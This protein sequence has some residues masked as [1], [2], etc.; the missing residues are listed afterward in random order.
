MGSIA[1]VCLQFGHSQHRLLRLEL[2]FSWSEYDDGSGNACGYAAVDDQ[3]WYMALSECSRANAAFSLYGILKGEEDAGCTSKTYINSFFTTSGAET[4]TQYMEFAGASFSGGNDDQA[5]ELSSACT[6]EAG[7]N[8]AA[9]DGYQYRHNENIARGSTSYSLACTTEGQYVEKAFSGQYCKDTENS[10]VTDAL[11]TF[12][13]EMGQIQCT[14]IY[15][16]GGNNNDDGGGESALDLLTVSEPC[17]ILEYP[18]S[19]PDPYRKLVRYEN[20][21]EVSAALSENQRKDRLR[22]AA[23][24]LM[25]LIG[26]LLILLSIMSKCS[27]ENQSATNSGQQVK[28]PSLW[29]KIK[30]TFGRIFLRRRNRNN[31][32]K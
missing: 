2:F 23:S 1:G 8:N 22:K 20:N 6:A 29:M 25:M 13:A 3:S 16:S 12:N 26:S 19:C 4:F 10:R 9:D 15:R 27:D 7:E 32:S 18:D 28:K 17:D 24:W 31:A 21:L 30:T 14:E 11:A 5:E